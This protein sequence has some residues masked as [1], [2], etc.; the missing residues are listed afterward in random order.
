MPRY[1]DRVTLS[2]RIRREFNLRGQTHYSTADLNATLDTEYAWCW[3]WLTEHGPDSFGV[4]TALLPTVG[5]QSY[6]LLPADLSDHG[7]LRNLRRLASGRYESV[8]RSSRYHENDID[9]SGQSRRAP[10][11]YWIE[12]PSASAPTATRIEI[13]P[14][15]SGVE[16]LEITYVQQAPT[17]AT[18]GTLLDLWTEHVERTFCAMVAAKATA[19]GDLTNYQKAQ[20]EMAVGLGNLGIMRGRRDSNEPNW[21]ELHQQPRRLGPW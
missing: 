2:A 6:V 7:G 15:P 16:D 12:G 13:R 8:E 21:V 18:D 1:R 5:G 10:G 9:P 19:S 17:F 4:I 11:V 14:I 3:E 20:Q